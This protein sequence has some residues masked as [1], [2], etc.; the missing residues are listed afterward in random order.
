MRIK[1]TSLLVADQDAALKF[2]TEILGF[3]C[4]SDMPMGEFRW[5]TVVSP[6]APDEIELVLEPNV[7]A[8]AKVYQEALFDQQ[9][10]FTAFEV[11]DIDAEYNRLTAADVAFLAPP[12]TMG[13][14]CAAVLNDTCG[15]WI[16]LYQNV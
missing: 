1:L 14:V 2:Y 12:M 6:Q 10:P 8:A 16:Q 13:P 4:K 3:V 7:N 15:N 11:D 9:I 5:L